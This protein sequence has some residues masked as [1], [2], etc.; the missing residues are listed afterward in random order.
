MGADVW[1]RAILVGVVWKLVLAVTERELA[2]IDV[3][4]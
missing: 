3:H 1:R 2:G 4:I